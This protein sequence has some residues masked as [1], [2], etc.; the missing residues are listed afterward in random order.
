MAIAIITAALLA[1]AFTVVAILSG[2]DL[3]QTKGKK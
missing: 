2:N 1:I 3:K